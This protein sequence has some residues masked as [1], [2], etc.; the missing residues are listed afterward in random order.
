[1]I[2]KKRSQYHDAKIHF[3]NSIS[4]NPKH[5]QAL[6]QLGHTYHILGNQII[7]E[8]YLKDSLNIDST[9][10]ETWSYLGLVLDAMDEH[11]RATECHLTSIRLEESSPL[12]PFSIIPRNILE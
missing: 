8:K 11:E 1:M 2:S 12:L 3:Q 7:A 6:Q 10:H 5:A 9:R 4:I